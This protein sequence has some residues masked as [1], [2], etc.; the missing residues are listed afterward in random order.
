MA[1]LTPQERPPL[2]KAFKVRVESIPGALHEMVAEAAREAVQ[3]G[4]EL[5]RR[6]GYHVPLRRRR[7]SV[8]QGD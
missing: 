6:L 3:A 7:R 5:A 8:A 2:A 4:D 1:E